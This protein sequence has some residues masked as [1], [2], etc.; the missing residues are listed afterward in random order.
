MHDLGSL[1]NTREACIVLNKANVKS[2]VHHPYGNIVKELD[3]YF[4]ICVLSD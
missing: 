4:V 3:L 1:V 2:G